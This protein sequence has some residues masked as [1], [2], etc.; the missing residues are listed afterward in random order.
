MGRALT[1]TGAAG[2]LRRVPRCG[3]AVALVAGSLL[4]DVAMQAGMVA[5]QVRNYRL[6]PEARSR[7]NTSYMTCAYCGGAAGSWLGAQTFAAF[8]WI[9]VC[10]VAAVLAG[11]A[12]ARHVRW[13]R[14]N[15]SRR[16]D[17]DPA[18][19]R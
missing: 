7:V 10:A 17:G 9:G 15:H 6:R 1:M 8:G 4:L 5:N 11:A 3:R 2:A 16:R 14:H 12:L 18:P 19:H 13:L